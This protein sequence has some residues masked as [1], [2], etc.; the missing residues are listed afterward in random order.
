MYNSLSP[1]Y[2]AASQTSFEFGAMIQKENNVDV[3]LTYPLN[4]G[5]ATPVTLSGGAEYRKETY[6]ATP[7]D[8]QS[9][10]AGPYASPHPLYIQV[11]PGVYQATGT[12]TVAE[13][14]AASGYGGTSPTFAGTSSQ[15]SQAVYIGAEGDPVKDL[16]LGFTG[17]YESYQ[18][19]GSKSV[20]KVNALWKTTDTVSLRATM[21]TGFHAPSPG[22][23]DAQVLTTSFVQGVSLQQGTFPVTSSIAQY[24]GA[25]PLKPETSTNYGLGLVFK[26]VENIVTTIDLYQIDVSN[27]IFI[28]ESYA[29]SDADIAKL[30]AL[31]SVGSG[32][33]V[34]YFTNSLDTST[35]GVDLVSTYKTQFLEG[36]LDWSLAYNY[37]DTNVTKYDPSAIATYQLI[38]IKNLAPHNRATL[39]AQ[40]AREEWIV[41][42]REN[43]FGSWVDSNDYPTAVDSAGNVTA[44]QV[45]GAKVTT[46][47]DLSYKMGQWVTTL[48]VS[49]LF[50]VFP[51]KIA[52]TPYTPIY[53]ITGSTYDG[54]IYPR[55]GGPFGINGRFVFV[56]V[57]FKM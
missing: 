57:G 7:G 16:S 38:D 31:A 46:D 44:G 17:R 14:P 26:P 54:E 1:S 42:I 47:F 28:S 15:T 4:I 43:Y 27:R 51:D 34:Q 41:N 9:Y 53:P 5:W 48:G 35:K 22:Q 23:N 33:T 50:N 19:F 11:S 30:P 37:N 45:F 10:G 3:D 21:G 55:N 12:F 25:K 18:T 49:N 13:S 8:L 32:G 20:G 29:V 56:N 2:G 6:T 39:S 24:Y 40:W 52:A 36:R